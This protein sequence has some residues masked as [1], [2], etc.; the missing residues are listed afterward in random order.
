MAGRGPQR[1]ERARTKVEKRRNRG[2]TDQSSLAETEGTR[3]VVRVLSLGRG[4]A[5][6]AQWLEWGRDWGAFARFLSRGRRMK[7]KEVPGTLL[8]M[9]DT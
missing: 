4:L 5:F 9:W 3:E 8:F 1:G 7:D 6:D 2:P